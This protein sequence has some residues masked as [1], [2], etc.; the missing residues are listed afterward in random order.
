[1]RYLPPLVALRAFDAVGRT[2]TLKAAARELRVTPAAIG[3]Q[4]RLLEAFVGVE[5]FA[6]EAGGLSLTI[7][8]A[9]FYQNVSRAFDLVSEAAAKTIVKQ[10]QPVRIHSLPSFASLWLAPRLEGFYRRHPGIDVEIKTVGY[11]DYPV[12][13]LNLDADFAI[14]FGS[15]PDLWPDVRVEKLVQEVLVPVCSAKVLRDRPIDRPVDLVAHTLLQVPRLREGWREWFAAMKVSDHEAL[16]AIANGPRFDTIQMAVTTAIEGLGV[17]IASRPLV[18][19]YIADGALVAPLALGLV[20]YNAY[21]LLSGPGHSM[22]PQAKKF[23]AWIL[24]ELDTAAAVGTGR[25]IGVAS[26]HAI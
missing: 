4:I 1:M 15:N 23:R 9:N 16:R 10:E 24:A 22:S 6:R 7:A 13:L 3:H 26:G 20:S 11:L 21:W 19:K 14:R 8:G 18:E 17:A 12:D 25:S 2:G 5:L